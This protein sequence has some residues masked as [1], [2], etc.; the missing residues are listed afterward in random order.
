MFY[1]VVDDHNL[2][3]AIAI[4][5]FICQLTLIDVVLSAMYYIHGQPIVSIDNW[6]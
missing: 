1:K 3:K 4:C 5:N 6:L 2:Q